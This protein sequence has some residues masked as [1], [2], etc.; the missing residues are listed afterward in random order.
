MYK[1]ILRTFPF[2]QNRLAREVHDLPSPARLAKGR[3]LAQQGEFQV[4]FFAL[5][6]LD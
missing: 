1:S 4:F 2:Y 5:D 3:R 6:H